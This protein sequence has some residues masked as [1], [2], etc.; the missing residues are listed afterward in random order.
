MLKFEGF[1]IG[2]RI[3]AHDFQPREETVG[4]VMFVEGEIQ[5]IV[6]AEELGFKAYEIIVDKDF[7][8]QD[9]FLTGENSRIG[10]AIFVP[11]ETSLDF[12]NRVE[13]L[14]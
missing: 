14:D 7:Y 11:M 5:R 9:G 3:R 8:H 2:Q 1:E 10:N 13:L 4:S 12:E 6:P